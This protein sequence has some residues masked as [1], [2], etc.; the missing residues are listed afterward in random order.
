MHV[1]VIRLPN[2]AGLPQWAWSGVE[3]LREP[4]VP[5]EVLDSVIRLLGNQQLPPKHLRSFLRRSGAT[6]HRRLHQDEFGP[7]RADQIAALK[8]CLE[9]LDTIALQLALLPR[10]HRIA[11]S[12]RFGT[13]MD[14]P[15][16]RLSMES[17]LE[18][19]N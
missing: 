8:E 10:D 19:I 11:L 14:F 9:R 4:I 3:E 12:E 5:D 18:L 2:S 6:F 15:W 13:C 17:V 16:S 1:Q 7:T